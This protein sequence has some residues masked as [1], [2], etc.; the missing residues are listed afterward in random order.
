MLLTHILAISKF[1][2]AAF[3]AE[4]I[5]ALQI[6]LRLQS[7]GTVLHSSEVR[8]LALVA[9]IKS[10][11]FYCKLL[12][13]AVIVVTFSDDSST[14]VVAFLNRLL[15]AKLNDAILK[16][17]LF[18]QLIGNDGHVVINRDLLLAAWAIKV[19]K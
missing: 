18:S 14:F 8:L 12:K 5:L 10:A 19:A 6:V 7:L 1:L 15:Y 17:Q 3:F 13:L 11:V 9:F 4:K 2:N 16:L